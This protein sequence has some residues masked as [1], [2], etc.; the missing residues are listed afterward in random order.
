MYFIRK[1]VLMKMLEEKPTAHTTVVQLLKQDLNK[2]RK[3]TQTRWLQ[4]YS[5]YPNDVHNRVAKCNSRN[6]TLQALE[7]L[8]LLRKVFI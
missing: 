8:F 1:Y 3:I 6:L 4:R 2:R 5:M 7:R